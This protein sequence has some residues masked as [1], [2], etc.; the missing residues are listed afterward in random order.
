MT[1]YHTATT[2]IGDI[3]T[4]AR[5]VVVS[6]PVVTPPT[7]QLGVPTSGR[8]FP[9]GYEPL[10][11]NP[12]GNTQVTG[13]GTTGDGVT[14]DYRATVIADIP[15]VYL[16]LG[17][18]AANP[19]VAADAM[20]FNAGAGVGAVVAQSTPLL[21]GDASKSMLFGGAGYIALGNNP[22]LQLQRFTLEAIVKISA[23][24]AGGTVFPVVAFDSSDSGVFGRGYKF[25]I[26]PSRTIQL[27]IGR[28]TGAY[29]IAESSA[30]LA[31]NTATH[32]AATFDGAQGSVF[33]NGGFQGFF[34]LVSAPPAPIS[35]TNATGLFVGYNPEGG[36]PDRFFSGNLQE[37]AIYNYALGA[38]S[39]LAHKVKALG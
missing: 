17:D 1:T 4:Y 34:F 15:K 23:S 21:V 27:W 35:F 14:V 33:I 19:L 22:A 37:V 38:P 24:P 9:L 12:I 11:A 10:L 32:I 5:P 3:G 18:V 7:P 25:V 20:G 28:G 6:T 26:T 8:I 16:R 29:L 30:T 31:L 39:L 13:G 2:K 36:A